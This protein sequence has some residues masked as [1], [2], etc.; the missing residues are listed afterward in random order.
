MPRFEACRVQTLHQQ[1]VAPPRQA[2]DERLNRSDGSAGG[3]VEAHG[4][5]FSRNAPSCSLINGTGYNE[6]PTPRPSQE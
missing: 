5:G 4:P 3:G 1:G 2:G 6:S